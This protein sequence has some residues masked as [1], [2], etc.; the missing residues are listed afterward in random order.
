MTD[1]LKS[2][3]KVIEKRGDTSHQEEMGR[4]EFTPYVRDSLSVCLTIMGI[5]LI[6]STIPP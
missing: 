4:A 6:T 3:T 5:G 2:P 1:T